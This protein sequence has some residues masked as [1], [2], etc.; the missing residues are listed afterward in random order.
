[1]F[2]V[3]SKVIP[4]DAHLSQFRLVRKLVVIVRIVR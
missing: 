2:K 1:M 4:P 3:V